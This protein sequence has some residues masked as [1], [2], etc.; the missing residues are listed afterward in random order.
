MKNEFKPIK[1]TPIALKKIHAIMEKKKVPG[2]YALRIGIQGAGCLGNTL[3]LGFD[4]TKENDF[5]S[6]VKDLRIL[7]YNKDLMYVAGHELDYIQDDDKQGF[8]FRLTND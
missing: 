3:T 4:S 7:I 1:I 5:Q 2:D 6:S 8:I